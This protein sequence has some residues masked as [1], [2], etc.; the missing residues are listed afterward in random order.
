MRPLIS[1]FVNKPLVTNQRSLRLPPELVISMRL[2]SQY[3]TSRLPPEASAYCSRP[4]AKLFGPQIHERPVCPPATAASVRPQTLVKAGSGDA[5]WN[6][7]V[8][9]GFV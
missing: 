9:C 8:G 5:A 4:V 6:V 2:L 1:S 3:C 7:P